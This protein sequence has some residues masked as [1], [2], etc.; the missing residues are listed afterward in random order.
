VFPF[1][2]FEGV[3]TILGPEMRSTG[4]VMGM[5]QAFA[6]AF[7]KAQ[8]AAGTLLPDGGVAFLSV[9]DADKKS[10]IELGK[11]LVSLGFRLIATGGTADALKRAGVEVSRINK[12]YQGSP[13]CVDA[14]E[15][16]DVHFVVNT[17][18]GAK[19]IIDSHSLR[20]TAL[21]K[22]IAYFTTLRGARAAAL[23]IA[24]RRTGKISVTPLQD[25]HHG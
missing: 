21:L 9:R 13:H 5:D 14:M 8:T 23:A 19:A 15:S 16:G 11:E 17:T 24:A 3:D 18:E 4:E 20:R 10:A 22:Q 6:H 7:L 1:V 25:Y 12:V 2:K